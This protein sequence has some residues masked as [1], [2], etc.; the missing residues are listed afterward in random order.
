MWKR[1]PSVC[2]LGG[3]IVLGPY[4]LKLG[5][6]NLRRLVVNLLPSAKIQY[7]KS[8]VDLLDTRSREIIAEKRSLLK[9]GGEALLQQV[10]EGHDV[11]SVLCTFVST[12]AARS[13]IS[14]TFDCDSTSEY[15]G[16]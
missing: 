12:S 6:P 5:P 8:N 11:M 9:K 13:N 15:E 4:V 2:A 1:S 14:F 3:M 7:V 10:G 16:F